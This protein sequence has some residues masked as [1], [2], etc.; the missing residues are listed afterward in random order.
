[1]AVIEIAITANSLGLIIAVQ[2]CNTAINVGVDT[3]GG[4]QGDD[5]TVLGSRDQAPL[6]TFVSTAWW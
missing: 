3:H 2:Q 6:G 4:R 1:M 5:F